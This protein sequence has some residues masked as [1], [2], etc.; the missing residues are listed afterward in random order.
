MRD[1]FG[2]VD[3]D[4]IDVIDFVEFDASAFAEDDEPDVATR[5]NRRRWVTPAAITSV[6]GIAVAG[7]LVWSPWRT[8]ETK[9]FPDGATPNLT[10]TEE[11]VFDNPP[12]EL[13]AASLGN[14]SGENQFFGGLSD[15]EG[16]FFAEPG[17][18][19]D[20][21][22]ERS[23]GTW[24]AFFSVKQGSE[25]E[26][27]LELDDSETAGTVQNTPA[28]IGSVAGGTREITFGPVDGWI[29]SVV[30]SDMS[31]PE[32]LN[33]AEAVGV[34]D[35]VPT[36]STDRVL[37]TMVPI[38]DIAD[39]TVAV[40]TL[41]QATTPFVVQPGIVSVHYGDFDGDFEDG[42]VAYSIATQPVASGTTMAMLRFALGGQEGQSVHGQDAIVVDDMS[43]P[44]GAG[45]EVGSVVAWVEG[46]RLIVVVGADGIEATLALA[47]SVRPATEDEWAEVVDVS[48]VSFIPDDV[49]S[50]QVGSGVTLYEGVDAET[51]T[52]F[53]L[54]AQIGEDGAMSICTE[55]QSADA[56]ES[57]C[58]A[59]IFLDVSLLRYTD[60][61]T[62]RQFVYAMVERGLGADAEIRITLADGTVDTFPLVELSADLPGL[63]A[64]T[65]LPDEFELVELWIGEE[66]VATL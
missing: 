20:V 53:A 62:G 27:D 51:G 66:V 24:A 44:F 54:T 6:I 30:S 60:G 13:A 25:F 42:G 8:D 19:W 5:P 22:A 11:L 56:A 21:F 64:A 55:Q 32:S 16:Y 46:G 45:G 10:L 1:A 59:E 50:I 29:F 3:P 23:N 52:T 31:L 2:E 61:P 58:D 17:V 37:G 36:L 9:S 12:A 26:P 48:E 4:E 65:V 38:G 15:A 7:L 14:I 18:T 43:D 35:G 34:D 63:A 57:A 39:Y 47:E 41:I 33:F 40:N 28:V 49:T